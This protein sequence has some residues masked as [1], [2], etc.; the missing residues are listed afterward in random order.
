[1]KRLLTTWGTLVALS[2]TPAGAQSAAIPRPG[3]V[4]V[5][6]TP[7]AFPEELALI[8][9]ARAILNTQRHWNHRDTGTCSTLFRLSVHCA[10]EQAAREERVPTAVFEAALQEARLV[11]WDLVVS[12]EYAHPL[13]DY[14][15]DASTSFADV[16]RLLRWLH[17]RVSRRLARGPRSRHAKTTPRRIRPRH[18]SIC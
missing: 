15:N 4:H 11:I 13:M 3:D 9:R 17:T 18:P 12:R 8:R 5:S 2:G 16:Q 7:L 1:M 14:N 10:L 6:A